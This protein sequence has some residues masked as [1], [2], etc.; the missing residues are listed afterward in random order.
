MID[1]GIS[2]GD[3]LVVNSAI[4]YYEGRIVVA[5]LN[6]GFTVKWFHQSQD[7]IVLMPSNPNYPPIYVHASDDFRVFGT[8]NILDQKS[9]NQKDIRTMIGL[10]DVNNCYVSCERSFNP[11]LEGKAVV[12]LSN[13][14][15]CVIARSNEAKAL[16]IKMG[17]PYFQLDELQKEY[18]LKVFSSN[19]TLY[20]DM[21]ARIM[22]TLG[23]FVERV[24][25]Y[26]IDEAFARSGRLRILVSRSVYVCPKTSVNHSAVASDTCKRGYCPHKNTLQSS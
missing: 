2:E 17:I 26:S 18:D 19:Y 3:V 7:F 21:S 1:A 4:E 11:S 15:G 14:D 16:G 20:G 9:A 10:V 22:A 13:N 23:R 6:D 12:V 24:E 25:V 5:W 8:G